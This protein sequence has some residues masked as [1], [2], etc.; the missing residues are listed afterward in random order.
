MHQLCPRMSRLRTHLT[1][2]FCRKD[3]RHRYSTTQNVKMNFSISKTVLDSSKDDHTTLASQYGH[4]LVKALST[5]KP[6]RQVKTLT[7]PA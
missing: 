1:S 7:K 6:I 5:S 2:Y 3:S 4:H